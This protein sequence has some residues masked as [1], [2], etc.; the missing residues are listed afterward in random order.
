MAVALVLV[1]HSAQL[2]AGLAELA[3][4]MAGD[5]QIVPA[6]GL[7]ADGTGADGLAAGEFTDGGIGTSFDKVYAAISQ[8]RETGAEVLV[9]TDLG[10]AT[11]TVESVL[12]FLDDD[13]VVFADAPFVEAAVA[14]AVAAQGGKTL[15]ECAQIARDA[16]NIFIGQENVS[17]PAVQTNQQ[18]AADWAVMED[19]VVA[20]ETEVAAVTGSAETDSVARESAATGTEDNYSRR[21]R[22]VDAVGLHARPAAKI[23]QLA[24]DTDGHVLLNGEPADSLLS[25]LTLG[26][27]CGEEVVISSDD[28][29]YNSVVDQVAEAIAAGLD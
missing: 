21:V 13:G 29:R 10:S 20:A 4:Q 1:S 14:S 5:V 22:V 9:L 3:A 19:S 25:L 11:L 15:S 26:I 7:M 8:L 16:A 27:G 6:G 12:D 18:P 2:A 23:A 24:A 17:K 28:S